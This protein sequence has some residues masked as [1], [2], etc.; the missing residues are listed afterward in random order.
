[1]N[2]RSW[3]LAIERTIGEITSNMVVDV[4]KEFSVELDR[5]IIHPEK[6]P[7]KNLQPE[8]NAICVVMYQ[9]VVNEYNGWRPVSLLSEGV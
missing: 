1:M 7:V 5:I 3:K 8:V 4:P 2:D 9:W 6:T